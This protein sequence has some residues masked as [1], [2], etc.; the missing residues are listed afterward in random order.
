MNLA[1]TVWRQNALSYKPW[2]GARIHRVPM[3]WWFV[4]GR[5]NFDKNTALQYAECGVADSTQSKDREKAPP[6]SQLKKTRP[7]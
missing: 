1:A 7:G 3:V 2:Q 6:L 5:K 4:Q